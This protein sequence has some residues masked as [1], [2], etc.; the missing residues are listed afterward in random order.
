MNTNATNLRQ[1]LF[2]ILK[3]TIKYNEIVNITT[4]DGNVVMMSE[5]DF[6]GIIA[7]LELSS[8]SVMKEKILAGKE[9]PP[10]DCVDESEVIW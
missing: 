6:N 4:K 2:E 1:N 10:E 3:Q 8:N 5:E 7:T 9:T